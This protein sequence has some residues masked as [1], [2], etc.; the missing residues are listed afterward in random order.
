MRPNAKTLAM[1]DPALAA[2]LGAIN[3]SDFGAE[4]DYGD[5]YGAE[6]GDDYGAE[7]PAGV[8]PLLRRPAPNSAAMAQAFARM[9]AEQAQSRRRSAILDP[10]RGSN[11]KVERY[12][13][14]LNAPVTLGTAV[15]VSVSRNPDV[16]IRP[17][18]VTINAPTPGFFMVSEIK[19]ANVSVTMG[20]AED[21]YNYSALGVGQTLD[22]PTLTPAMR[23]SVIGNYTGVVPPGFVGASPYLL[24]FN[25]KG[26]ASVVA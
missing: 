13:F 2:A 25:F 19:V 17:Q 10:N 26:P 20:D 9:Q 21:G 3:G 6:F 14:S 24:N 22:M 7:A 4:E 8:R 18:R 16:T 11:I 23:A 12:S 1:R 5:D 15:G